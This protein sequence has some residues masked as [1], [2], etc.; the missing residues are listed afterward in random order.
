V[1]HPVFQIYTALVV[2]MGMFSAILLV[3]CGYACL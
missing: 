2:L 1:K 3:P